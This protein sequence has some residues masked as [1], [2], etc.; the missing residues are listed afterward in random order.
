MSAEFFTGQLLV[1]APSLG[2]PNFSQAVLLLI[3][4][5]DSGALGVVLNRPTPVDV[6]EVLPSWQPYATGPGVLF[7]GGPVGLNNALALAA[8]PGL[9]EPLGWQRVSGGLGLVD[10]DAPPEVL[11]GEMSAM[12]IFAGYAG[13]GA[14]QLEDEIAEGSWFVVEAE[15]SDAFARNPDFLW[16]S[17]LRRQPGNLALLSTYAEDPTLN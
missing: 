14:G 5:S 1:A 3:E 6:A 12:R 9:E 16:R 15:A 7:Q 2:D 13:W 4:H 17:V 8:V 10:L 11:V